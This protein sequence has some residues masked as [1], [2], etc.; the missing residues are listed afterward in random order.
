M[1]HQLY[2][3]IWHYRQNKLFWRACVGL[4]CENYRSELKIHVL[5]QSRNNEYAFADDSD[6]S[7]DYGYWYTL[8][9]LQGSIWGYLICSFI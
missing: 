4:S 9:I 6:R 5:I 7:D 8:T 1:K 3:T 2:Q